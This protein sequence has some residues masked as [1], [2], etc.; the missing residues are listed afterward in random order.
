MN[1]P[2]LETL[3]G[4]LSAREFLAEYWQKKPLLIRQAVP[5]FAGLL[6]REELFELA[7]DEDVE[8]RYIRLPAAGLDG[9]WTT[10]APL[11][12]V[13][14]NRDWENWRERAVPAWTR[15]RPCPPRCAER[16]S[17]GP[18]WCRA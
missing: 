14:D 15:P 12:L 3:L 10:G 8:S 18:C 16:S 5:G 2:A 1:L 7:C 17:R 13:I 6:S 9:E 4:G 11:A